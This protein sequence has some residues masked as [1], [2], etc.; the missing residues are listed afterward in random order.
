MSVVIAQPFSGQAAT[1]RDDVRSSRDSVGYD[2]TARSF[3]AHPEFLSSASRIMK[4]DYCHRFLPAVSLCALLSGCAYPVKISYPSEASIHSAFNQPFTTL[5]GERV[6]VLLTP[7]LRGESLRYLANYDQVFLANSLR[8]RGLRHEY[9]ITGKGTPLVVYAKNPDS[10]PQEK[11][12][13]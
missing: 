6:R 12:Y 1:V 4:A 10:T 3:M 11:H 13:P 9:K 5:A 7:A 2:P 8:Q